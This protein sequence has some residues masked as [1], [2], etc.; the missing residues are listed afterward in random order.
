MKNLSFTKLTIL[1]AKLPSLVDNKVYKTYKKSFISK[2]QKL[3]TLKIYVDQLDKKEFN[4]A[5]FNELASGEI[6]TDS[7]KI[8]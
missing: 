5:S 6:A 3:N 2:K 1:P 4:E 7:N 8:C